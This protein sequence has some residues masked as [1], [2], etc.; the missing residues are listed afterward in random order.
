MSNLQTYQTSEGHPGHETSDAR[1]GP[2]AVFMVSMAILVFLA[3][4]L[5]AWMLDLF[6]LRADPNER[7]PAG[8]TD[9]EQIPP[10]PRL[11]A[12]PAIDL[13]KL[14]AKE[15]KQL[16]SYEWVDEATGVMRIPIER[17]MDII[18]ENGLPTRPQEAT[19]G[20]EGQSLR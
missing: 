1:V 12:Y 6:Q 17:A 13:E 2:I 20:D 9:Q 14:R 7:V 5:M 15:D 18:A 3:M 11:Q 10:E 4:L 16:N 19:K 8:L